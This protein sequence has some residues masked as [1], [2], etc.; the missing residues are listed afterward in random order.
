MNER[1]YVATLRAEFLEAYL[2][3]KWD[4]THLLNINM[5][6]AVKGHGLLAL[7]I[8]TTLAISVRKWL[9]LPI[10]ILFGI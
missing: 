7:R 4:I 5:I 2:A 8:T 10:I 9:A 6:D 1:G 3:F